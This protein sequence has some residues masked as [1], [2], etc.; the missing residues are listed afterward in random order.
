MVIDG[1]LLQAM[2]DDLLTVPGVRAVVL[3]GSRARGSHRPDSDV[4]LGL[5]YGKDLDLEALHLRAQVWH[6]GP[7]RIAGP[8]AWGPWVDGGAWLT[9]DGTA[10]DWILRDVDRLLEQCRRAV[11]GQFAFHSQPGHP[12]G[13]LDV[14]YAGEAASCR[15]LG[16]PDG[17]IARARA[18]VTPYPPALRRSMVT[19]LWQADFLATNASKGVARADLA[20]ITISCSSALLICAH[21][22]YASAGVWALNEKG[23]L[24]GLERLPVDTQGFAAAARRSLA[25]LDDT[26][27]GMA[28]TISQTQDLVE[29][30]R[31]SL[32]GTA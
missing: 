11:A 15:P 30:T 21:A 3:G 4:D 23:L 12:L 26:P 6:E 2:A 13:F 22:W 20:F 17:V 10:V 5:Y 16:D 7:A 9:V 28:S 1:R 19:N 29:M 27:E 32:S 24:P 31:S 25:A 18:L 8:G 14:S